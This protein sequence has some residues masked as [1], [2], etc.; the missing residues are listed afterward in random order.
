MEVAIAVRRKKGP[1]RG[2]VR[3]DAQYPEFCAPPL[4]VLPCER[5]EPSWEPF[6]VDFHGRLWTAMDGYGLRTGWLRTVW[7]A[8]DGYGR[9]ASIYGSEGWGFE[10]LRACQQ[11]L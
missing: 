8:A 11:G 9:P 7:T 6:A 3:T 4:P 5:W 2:H 10:F 1:R